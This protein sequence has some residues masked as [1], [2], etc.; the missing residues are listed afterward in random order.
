FNDTFGHQAGDKL[1][2]GAAA[3]W[4]QGLRGSGAV[5]ARYGGEEFLLVVVGPAAGEA[6]RLLESL[7]PLTPAG[8]TFS[9]GVAGW[10]RLEPV[11]GLVARADVALYSAKRGGRDRVVVVEG[12][13]GP[14][15]PALR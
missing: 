8:Q 14:R 11:A 3:A 7:R 15:A 10:D 9:A 5:L 12:V 2:Q 13:S 6:G 1:L 4:R